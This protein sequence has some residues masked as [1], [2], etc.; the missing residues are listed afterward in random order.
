MKIWRGILW[1]AVVGW[2][3]FM[4]GMS[5]KTSTQSSQISGSVIESVVSAV[6]PGYEKMDEPARQSLVAR[7]QTLV[8]KTAHFGE[9]GVLGMLLFGALST[10]RMDG[11]FRL[12]LAGWLCLLYALSDEI[13]QAFVPGRGPGLLDVCLDFAGAMT[14]ILLLWGILRAV[15]QRRERKKGQLSQKKQDF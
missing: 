1:L 5:A 12:F 11:R 13:H 4:F 2:M 14:G 15:S 9:Y 8:R 6:V 7:W 3:A 10:H